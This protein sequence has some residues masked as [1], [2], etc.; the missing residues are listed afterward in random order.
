VSAARATNQ[1][2]DRAAE[3]PQVV[4][5]RVRRAFD[6][7]APEQIVMTPDCGMKYLPRESAALLHAELFSGSAGRGDVLVEVEEVAPVVG[8]LDLTQPLVGATVVLGRP[9]RVVGARYMCIVEEA[10][11]VRGPCSTCTA[12]ASSG[13]SRTKSAFQCCRIPFGYRPSK[14]E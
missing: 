9:C 2:A 13:R 3:T 11:G 4:D 5:G 10:V 12:M 14:A 6:R 8:G 1:P 7:I